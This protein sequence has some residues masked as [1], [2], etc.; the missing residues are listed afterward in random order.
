MADDKHFLNATLADLKSA[1][2][3]KD[4]GV[5]D[6]RHSHDRSVSATPDEKVTF[7]KELGVGANDEVIDIP[8]RAEVDAL[9]AMLGGPKA[10]PAASEAFQ[11]AMAL[12]GV[13]LHNIDE[14]TEG[15]TPEQENAEIA[16]AVQEWNEVLG[17][18]MKAQALLQKIYAHPMQEPGR[19][20]FMGKGSPALN[21]AIAKLWQ[22]VSGEPITGRDKKKIDGRTY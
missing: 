21:D 2:D 1:A 3:F 7:E 18:P 9:T 13:G 4:D 14:L 16:E 8:Q 17:N 20:Y 5:L 11:E 15:L 6:E 19:S 10:M 22:A 12:M